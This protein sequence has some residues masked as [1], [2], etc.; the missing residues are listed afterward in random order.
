MKLPLAPALGRWPRSSRSRRSSGRG[1][2]ICPQMQSSVNAGAACRGSADASS[3]Y[4]GGR[5]GVAEG[6][7][8]VWRRAAERCGGGSGGSGQAA[9]SST[10]HTA[11]R[12]CAC[13]SHQI[14]GQVQP[15]VL[16]E[17]GQ[18]PLLVPLTSRFGVL[19]L[20]LQPHPGPLSLGR[21]R[22]RVKGLNPF[23]RPPQ[24]RS[25]GLHLADVPQS[26][27]VTTNACVLRHRRS[28]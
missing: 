15:I 5:S 13:S 8:A 18:Q 23:P 24:Q 3:R 20:Q 7:G 26:N 27:R 25:H 10:L 22:A 4:G 17:E 6:G 19:N 12:T 2:G 1:P 14:V 21:R 16:L 9:P 11:P 28:W